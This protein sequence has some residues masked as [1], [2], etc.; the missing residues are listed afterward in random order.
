MLGHIV[1]LNEC[2]VGH[3]VKL[4]ECVDGEILSFGEADVVIW[5]RVGDSDYC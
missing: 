1:K 2:V 4:N 3:I 5:R